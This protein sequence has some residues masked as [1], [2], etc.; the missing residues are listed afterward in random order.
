MELPVAHSPHLLFIALRSEPI[1]RIRVRMSVGTGGRS[2]PHVSSPSPHLLFIA[3]RDGGPPTRRTAGCP[4]SGR[5]SGSD[6]VVGPSLVEI[7]LA[8]K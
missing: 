6:S 5:E 7:N 1:D 8:E 2:E 3:L 4:R